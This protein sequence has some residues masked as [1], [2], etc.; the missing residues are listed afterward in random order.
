MEALHAEMG[1]WAARLKDLGYRIAT[2][3]VGGGTPTILPLRDLVHLLDRIWAIFQVEDGAEFT[4]EA[5]PGTVDRP[6]LKA[7]LDAGVNRLS[8][9]AQAFQDSLLEGLGR[10]HT[11]REIVEAFCLARDAGFR[12]INLDIIYALPGQTMASWEETL[13]AVTRLD[14]EHVSAY[15][16][17]LEEG[18]RLWERVTGGVVE[19]C[20][21][22]TEVRMYYAAKDILEESGYEHYELSNFSK[23]GYRCL[24]NIGYWKIMPYIGLGA[25]AHSY[26][27]RWRFNNVYD[28]EEYTERMSRGAMP[29]EG[30]RE[31]SK[32][33]EMS[34]FMILGLRMLEGVSD[35]EFRKRF[36]VGI[37]DVFGEALGKC[38][39][40]GLAEW[41]GSSIRLT[42]R[43]LMLSNEVMRDFLIP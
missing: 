37:S 29:V 1:A 4:V 20:D 42:R 10:I 43:G 22:D 31:I 35:R 36:G 2:V 24:H 3:Y 23:P 28:A 8:L 41:D 16:L 38:N 32:A 15:G 12:N 33:E 9:G 19:A 25:G 27:G 11:A 7:M 40:L 5:N 26:F 34:D 6:K 13:E 14:P 30:G 39:S 21:E 18:T 17:M